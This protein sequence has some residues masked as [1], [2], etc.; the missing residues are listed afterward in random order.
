MKANSVGVG[1]VHNGVIAHPFMTSMLN[2]VV[3]DR[4]RSHQIGAVWN[5]RGSLIVQNRNKLME[6]FIKS[7]LQ[8]FL[9]LDTDIVFPDDTLDQLLA[10]ALAEDAGV[11]AGIYWSILRG[12]LLPVWTSPQ[13]DERG[14]PMAGVQIEDPAA[15]QLVPLGS[16]G[17]G[18][19]LIRRD[20]IEKM[21]E[22]YSHDD[23]RW[24]GHDLCRI[25][26]QPVRLGEDVTFCVR[27][28]QLG[29][30]I[31]GHPG[32]RCGHIKPHAYTFEDAVFSAPSETVMEPLGD[33]HV[34]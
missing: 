24:F 10:A 16:T 2:L 4:E 7:D 28:R 30:K 25:D 5:S 31:I 1:Y 32:V 26:N 11:T 22:V 15:D 14:I 23:H 34:A 27:A 13:D 33:R 8:W 6:Q 18:C 29:F 3:K 20:V 21:N 19:T 17:M 12:R 9:F